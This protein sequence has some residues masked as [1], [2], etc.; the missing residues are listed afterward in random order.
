MKIGIANRWVEIVTNVGII[1]GL[2]LVGAQMKQ[3]ADLLRMQMLVEESQS[4]IEHER[5]ML[6]ENPAAVWAKSM[7]SPLDLTLEERRVMEA[8][9]WVFAEQLRTTRRLAE[10]GLLGEDEWD[11][12][13]FSDANFYY[14]N[15]YGAAW[16]K[17]YSDAEYYP[18]DLVE[19]INEHLDGE[20]NHT[21]EYFDG[22]IRNLEESLAEDPN[23]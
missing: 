15:P 7:V 11:D 8:Y 17:E 20:G 10:E 2:V 18:A 5:Q 14:G 12:R 22:Q 16:W 21:L 19:T 3:N 23:P 9:L 6:G 4:V 13:V 1:G